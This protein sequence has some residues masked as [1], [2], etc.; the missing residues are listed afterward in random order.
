MK[1]FEKAFE[2]IILIEGGFVDDPLDAGGKTKYGITERVARS[3]NYLGE[4]R[5]LSL[6]KAKAIYELD[7]WN[8]SKLGQI[9]GVS[10]PIALELFE[11]E[12]NCGVRTAAKAFQRSINAYGKRFNGFQDL[13]V[14]GIIG[15]QTLCNF[16][17]IFD[18]SKHTEIT[19]L[20]MINCIQGEHYIKCIEKTATNSKFI[21][22]WFKRVEI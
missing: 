1:S 19:L 11:F 13:I 12:V 2:E 16:N 6:E 18:D 22:G 15:H 5:D 17:M 21:N 8:K 3:H 10:E 4:I 9:A 14:D 20:K 7:Y